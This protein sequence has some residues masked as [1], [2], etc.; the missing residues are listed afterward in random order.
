MGS[1]ISGIGNWFRNQFH[2]PEGKDFLSNDAPVDLNK[3]G[4]TASIGGG[5]GLAIGAGIG[6][7]AA[8]NEI[9]KVPV[10]SVTHDYRIPVT[11]SEELGLIPSD[12][13]TPT[14]GWRNGY[15][16]RWNFPSSDRGV[17]IEGVY[18]DNPVYGTNGEPR[19]QVTSE[20]FSG[21]G[22]PVT[23]WVEKPIK[24]HTMN[25]YNHNVIPDIE[26][27]YDHT[28][29]WTE[30]EAYTVYETETEYYQNCVDSYDSDGGTSQDCYTDSRTVSV[31]H[32]EYRDVERSRDVYRDELRG[33][34][35]RY[36]PDISS[37]TV[38]TYKVPRVTFDHG[39]DVSSYVLKGVLLGAGL[40]AIALGVANVISQ[41]SQANSQPGPK[42]P[43]PAPPGPKP[44]PKPPAP[45]KPDYGGVKNHAHDG[46]RH[47]HA[48]GDR[49]HYH[50]CP[51]ENKDPLNT[52]VI[53]FKPNQVPSGYKEE[54]KTACADNGTV[55]Y[56]QKGHGA[57]GA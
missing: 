35:E 26:E 3:V 22:R 27:V 24:H 6:M 16:L 38:G 40:G 28:E 8:Q 56:T 17:P 31:P 48:G 47:T 54:D 21:H 15:S 32:T 25:G 1:P 13:Y 14:P 45:P 2:K 55:C 7:I 52:E 5:A 9:S 44:D 20:T 37:R 53:C 29:Y 33:Y 10:E 46:R 4:K 11:R 51:D 42:P 39:I 41:K 43:A 12:R 50:G 18:R 36:S 57:T 49:W 19:M 34:Y 23:E 30:S